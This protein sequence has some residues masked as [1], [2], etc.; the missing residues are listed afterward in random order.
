M[1]DLAPLVILVVACLAIVLFLVRA[2]HS[3]KPY[4]VGLLVLLGSY[5]RQLAPGFNMIHPL[6][7]VVRVDLRT[8][9]LQ[10]APRQIPVVGGTVRVGGEASFRVTD[11]P[12]SVFQTK[13]LNGSVQEV[14]SAAI[15][16]SLKGRDLA[17]E[18]SGGFELDPL[19]RAALDQSAAQFGAK[20]ESV[21]LRLE[22]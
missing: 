11:A 12:R 19:A 22:R 2:A 10:I 4:E 21:T 16:E 7:T 1:S 9:L 13:D 20:I 6:G 15:V 5:Q 17:R 3:I 8:R 18:G 14:V